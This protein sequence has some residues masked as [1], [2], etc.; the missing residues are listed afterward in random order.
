MASIFEGS[1]PMPST[2]LAE[3]RELSG[4]I[5]RTAFRTLILL[6]YLASMGASFGAA[7]AMAGSNVQD[8]GAVGDGKTL[9]TR[10]LQKAID[11]AAAAGGGNVVIPAGEYL[12]GT[13]FLRDH[14][15]L[16]L[17]PGSVLLGST[18][19][20]DY[21]TRTPTLRSYTDV[22]YVDKSLIYAE[23]VRNIAIVGQGTI[24]GQGG[25]TAFSGQPY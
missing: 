14:V 4:A 9:N 24:D 21:P 19:L 15:T 3:R 18:D 8:F 7:S 20:K 11:A 23:K 25:D 10:A 16:Q 2:L 6:A 22:N 13:L 1:R 12:T 17:E 5:W